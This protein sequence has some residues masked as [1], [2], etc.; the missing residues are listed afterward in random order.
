MKLQ[1][2]VGMVCIDKQIATNGVVCYCRYVTLTF[3]I[4]SS[5][6]LS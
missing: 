1:P 4:R 3:P 2:E 6:V 5:P